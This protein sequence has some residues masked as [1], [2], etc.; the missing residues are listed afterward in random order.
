MSGPTT[1][2]RRAAPVPLAVRA[3]VFVAWL[4]ALLVALPAPVVTGRLAGVLVLVALGPA[5]LPRG[6]WGTSVAVVA[7]LGWLAGTAWYGDPPRLPALL[8]LAVLL[9]GGHSLTALAAVLPYDAQ[10]SAADVVGWL[11]R[12]AVVAGA[13][14][15]FGVA[16]LAVA[17]T[18]GR[19]FPAASLAG[20]GL[21]LALVWLLVWL[22]RRPADR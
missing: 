20:L 18:G 17:G 10:V 11:A 19:A 16:A 2:L 9:Y 22:Y 15:G 6:R 5:V 12:T 8:A 13:G 1:R 3:G 21:V 7:V 14:A 4:G